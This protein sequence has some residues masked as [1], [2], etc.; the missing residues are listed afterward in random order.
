M[1]MTF[2]TPE[3]QLACLAD[4]VI[5]GILTS[6]RLEA[7]A[8]TYG[9]PGPTLL[10]A[11]ARHHHLTKRTGIAWA[12]AGVDNVD[13]SILALGTKHNRNVGRGDSGYDWYPK[14]NI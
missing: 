5:M 2:A 11:N 10:A 14:G 13:Q 6:I 12:Y 9:T 4:P 1:A 7:S 8:G 3:L